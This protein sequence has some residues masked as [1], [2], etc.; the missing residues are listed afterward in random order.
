MNL[1]TK[2]D[3]FHETDDL[4]N[5]LSNYFGRSP[6]PR[7]EDNDLWVPVAD[8]TEDAKEYLIKAELPGL[9]RNEVKVTVEEGMLVISGER[10]SEHEEKDR[11]FHRIERS[12][13]NFVRSFT[14]PDNA[15]G[16]NIQAEFKNGILHIHLPKNK[17]ALKARPIEIEVH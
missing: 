9:E 11:K 15:D 16:A 4:S 7:R 14:L 3:L 6:L 12:Y 1:L 13:G 8:I 5:R 17:K 2:W 10:K